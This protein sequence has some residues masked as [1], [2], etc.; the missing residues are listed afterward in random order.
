[1]TDLERRLTER[2]RRRD[3]EIERLRGV[4][5]NIA[6]PLAHL[7]REAV[8]SGYHLSPMAVSI[9]ND[10]ETLKDMAR[11]ALSPKEGK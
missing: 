4:L 1:M 8:A 5:S 3:D 9:A 10:P 2:L 11:S 7:Q 6:Q